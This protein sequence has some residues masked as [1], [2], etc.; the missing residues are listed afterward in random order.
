M[1]YRVLPVFYASTRAVLEEKFPF[2]LCCKGSNIDRGEDEKSEVTKVG[3]ALYH[4]VSDKHYKWG[5]T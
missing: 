5:S 4:S 2:L 1:S 3:Q